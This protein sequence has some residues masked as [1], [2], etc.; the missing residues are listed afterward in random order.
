[1]SQE[2]QPYNEVTTGQE[3]PKKKGL[4]EEIQEMKASG[5][6]NS[7]EFKAKVKELEV[8]LGVDTLSPFKTNELD[9]FE[10]DL[11]AMDITDMM[12]M[13]K[14]AGLNPILDKT[15]LKA[16]LIKEFKAYTRNN[17]RNIAPNPMKQMELDPNNPLHAETIKILRN[18]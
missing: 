4:L 8:I 15:R 16:S 2:E 14:A 18:T 10:D 1:M 13:A 12:Q 17:R 5:N 9:I 6:T 7:E 11:K 3:Q